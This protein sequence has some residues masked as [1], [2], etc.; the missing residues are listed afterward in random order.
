MPTR[1]GPT[2][3][4]TTTVALGLAQIR[5]AASAGY[6]GQSR[7]ILTAAHSVGALASTK[8]TGNVEHFKLESGFP[9]LEDAIFVLR[10]AAM[11]ELAFKEITPK[12]VA[13]ARGL[14]PTGYTDAHLGTIPFGNMATPAYIRMEAVYTYPDG[15]NTMTIIFPRAQVVASIEMDFAAEEPASIPISIEAKRADSSVS[16]GSVAWDSAPLGKVV[17]DDG[18]QTTT[19]TTTTTTT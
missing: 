1:T 6:I 8:F 19:S 4:D 11:M 5:V 17:W 15:T 13:L 2:T 16:G 9:L 10:E 12:N 14:D 18:T 7:A 3:L